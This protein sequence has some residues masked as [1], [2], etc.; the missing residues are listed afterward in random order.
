M[1]GKVTPESY[2]LVFSNPE[3]PDVPIGVMLVRPPKG[4]GPAILN[5]VL[6]PAELGA[7]SPPRPVP[8]II[9]RWSDGAGVARRVEGVSG[10]YRLARNACTRFGGVTPAGGLHEVPMLGPPT[11][12]YKMVAYK[13][14]VLLMTLD[15]NPLILRGS[16]PPLA[17]TVHLTQ[18]CATQDPVVFQGA[19][20]IVS[21]SPVSLIRY[22]GTTWS[23]APAAALPQFSRM[24]AVT[25]TRAGVPRRR[26]VA[27]SG[28]GGAFYYTTGDNPFNPA[29]WSSAVP[30]ESEWPIQQLVASARH[31]YAIG[32]G[33]VFDLTENGETPCI[34]GE[35][36][37]KNYDPSNAATGVL[38]DR[39]LYVAARFGTFA[40]AL[41]GRLVDTLEDVSIGHLQPAELPTGGQLSV[42][43][44]L[45]GWL[46]QVTWNQQ[47][48][49][50]QLWYGIR[51]ER[52][53]SAAPWPITWHGSE[54]DIPGQRV[55]CTCVAAP[56]GAPRRM[57][58]ATQDLTT[59][60]PRLWWHDLPKYGSPL[61]DYWHGDAADRM[62]YARDWDIIQTEETL[63]DLGSVKDP[64]WWDVSGRGLGGPNRLTVSAAER[65]G[66]FVE[67]GSATTDTE[68]RFGAHGVRDTALT[69]KVTGA[70]SE[71]VPAVLD[72]VKGT[73]V[74]TV[75]ESATVQVPVMYGRGVALLNGAEDLQDADLTFEALVAL[76]KHG[77]IAATRWNGDLLEVRIEQGVRRRWIED[78]D[79]S[80]WIDGAILTLTMVAQ[81]M[82]HDVGHRHDL[83]FRHDLAMSHDT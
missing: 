8:V 33:G 40:I 61:Q 23:E 48:A 70:N 63:G 22:D 47:A 45:D 31:V 78:A 59:G 51:R 55:L 21:G 16:V 26:L 29:H 46:T 17:Y 19:L 62:G 4:R 3:Q 20:Y 53:G 66:P 68:A 81:P 27:T 24:A 52:S 83:A 14:D 7:V 72:Q 35:T 41:D 13:G 1:A 67:Q 49:K 38:Y 10:G 54:C 25:W 39:S 43:G 32:P 5:E 34:T 71:T 36:W 37:A 57:Y 44:T 15:N 73:W 42:L 75:E 74:V 76:T 60:R 28:N 56:L 79:G 77:S 65:R 11:T 12:I 82:R 64:L 69:V 58:I 80:G 30:I 9:D 2:D 6:E 50:S 18:N